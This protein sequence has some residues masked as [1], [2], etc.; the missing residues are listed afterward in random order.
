MKYTAIFGLAALAL[1]FS[2]C[3][4][5]EDATGL[6]QTNPQLPII[7]VDNVPVTPAASAQQA[8][9]LVQA[10]NDGG[11][12]TLATIST[13]SDFPEG[14]RAEVLSFEVSD[15]ASFTKKQTIAAVT[16]AEGNVTAQADDWEAAHQAIFG[17]NPKTTT[18]YVR[19]PAWAV[20]GDQSVRLGNENAYFSNFTT[21]VTPF[22]LFD[23]FVVEDAYY[24]VGSF[25]DWDFSKALKFS[26]SDY[27]PYDD[28]TFSLKVPA[29]TPDWEWVIIPEST[30]AAGHFVDGPQSSYGVE[31]SNSLKGSLVV[32][33]TEDYGT[34]GVISVNAGMLFKVNM[35]DLTYEIEELPSVLY[36]PGNS[37]GWSFDNC[38]QLTS[39]ETGKYRGFVYIN[40]IFKFTDAPNWDGTNYGD[41]GTDGELSTDG[42]AANLELPAEG[43]GLYFADVNTNDLTYTLTYISA[44]NMPGAYNG[45][46]I[47]SMMTSTDY[48]H[49]TMT[50]DL[51]GGEFKFAFNNSWSLSYGGAADDLQYNGPNS[52]APAGTYLVTLDLTSVPYTYTLT[53]Q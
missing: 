32:N 28:P 19:I 40:G 52:Q 33:D 24:L 23:G 44:V 1:G 37:N 39:Y 6:P 31:F 41:S 22:D 30:Y 3:D 25:C 4:E 34:A 46:D 2:A 8:I 38:Q 26:H 20:K 13:P 50:A 10:N 47:N 48:L 18:T 9:N 7:T 35:L 5:I 16:D 36:T 42:G 11:T 17:K 43:E 12:I 45:W 21:Q 51:Q 14:F 49:W 53:A 29:Q 15:D 27:D